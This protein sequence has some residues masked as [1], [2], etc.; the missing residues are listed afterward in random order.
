M[1]IQAISIVTIVIVFFSWNSAARLGAIYEFSTGK[2]IDDVFRDAG[3]SII[4]AS[5][6]LAE[7]YRG[8]SREYMTSYF[9]FLI[10]R[11]IWK[12]KP[13]AEFNFL[14][15]N[16]YSG[17]V[18]GYGTSVV[19]STML[20]EGWYYFGWS[21]AFWLFMVFGILSQVIEIVL[22]KNILL[23][24][25]LLNIVYLTFVQIRSTFLSYYQECVF[26]VLLGI[27]LVSILNILS[28]KRPIRRLVS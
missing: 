15:S 9:T 19:T 21:G 28:H 13:Y 26:S 14:I 16:W 5:L 17:K 24:G 25:M 23:F 18:V 22:S 4:P 3:G 10:P 6:I 20:G 1:T 12:T 8:N 27:V 2:V 11:A 7:N